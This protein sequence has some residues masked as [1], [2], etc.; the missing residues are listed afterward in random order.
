MTL[1]EIVLAMVLLAIISTAVLGTIGTLEN[2]QQNQEQMLSGYEVAHR[3]MLSYLDDDKS[4]PNRALPIEYGNSKFMYALDEE[5]VRMRLNRVQNSAD[6]SPQGLNR[7][8]QVTITVFEADVSLEYPRPG[9][10]LAQL[11]RV[12]DPLAPRN[13]DSAENTFSDVNNV[14]ERVKR[15]FE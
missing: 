14:L 2:L 4:M 8:R 5:Q 13:A 7:Y 10:Q 12:Y 15:I 9:A 1:L 6:S 3:L 11:T